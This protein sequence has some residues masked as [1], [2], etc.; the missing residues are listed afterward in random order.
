MSTRPY[1]LMSPR[2]LLQYL[3]L[4]SSSGQPHGH[5]DLGV[6]T[7]QPPPSR[8]PGLDVY[9]L[10]P[11]PPSAG[12]EPEDMLAKACP[13]CGTLVQPRAGACVCM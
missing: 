3:T 5:P 1:F 8:G 7:L 10:Q 2:A 9:S 11:P 6:H 13:H 4:P 12:D